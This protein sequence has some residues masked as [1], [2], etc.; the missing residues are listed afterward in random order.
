MF[1]ITKM[2]RLVI[3]NFSF[4]SM[5][6][7]FGDRKCFCRLLS[8]QPIQLQICIINMDVHHLL[9]NSVDPDQMASIEPCGAVFSY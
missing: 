2:H 6:D 1:S 5:S 4:N 7:H 9:K 3:D 8:F